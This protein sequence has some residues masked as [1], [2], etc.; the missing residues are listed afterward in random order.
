MRMLSLSV[1]FSIFFLASLSVVSAK[2]IK[3]LHL[4]L[5]KGC[6]ND[7]NQVA[8]ELDLDVT[9][10]YIQAIGVAK[11]DG[12]ACGNA[13]YNISHDRAAR[14]WEPSQRLF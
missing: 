12:Y 2:A 7:F 1:L 13:I 3:I 6:I 10:W 14:I 9:P 11:V 5:H 8:K 4:S